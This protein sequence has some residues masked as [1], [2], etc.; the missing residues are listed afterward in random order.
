MAWVVGDETMHKSE[1]RRQAAARLAT[2]VVGVIFTGS[3]ELA[4]ADMRGRVVCGL[5]ADEAVLLTWQGANGFWSIRTPAG[6]RLGAFSTE[7]AALRGW[8]EAAS[9]VCEV[10]I[11]VNL[12]DLRGRLY[13]L[14]RKMRQYRE[15]ADGVY[16]GENDP[17]L[18]IVGVPADTGTDADAAG[19]LRE[20]QG[21]ARATT[22]ER[23]LRRL[24]IRLGL[25]GQRRSAVEGAAPDRSAVGDGVSS[26]AAGEELSGG[27][28]LREGDV[29]RDCDVCP[30]MVVMPGGRF[31]LGRYEVT[32]GEYRV[33]AS[34]AAGGAGQGCAAD[35]ALGWRD[36]GVL[37][38][39]S[40]PVTCVS[41]D[42]AQDY[43]TWLTG[44][45][46][47][48]YRLPTEEEWVLAIGGAEP[49]CQSRRDGRDG[50]CPV[51]SYGSNDVGLSDMVGNVWE[52]MEDCYEGDCGS[53][54]IRGGGWG[55][56]ER[57]RDANARLSE[58]RYNPP[59]LP[60]RRVAPS[61]PPVGDRYRSNLTG[62]RIARTIDAE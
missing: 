26:R 22:F 17:R 10:T 31:A 47:A 23:G 54:V 49:G 19:E 55:S 13:R 35:R 24:A 15:T 62:F 34:A 33:Y 58:W 21:M 46:G 48:R 8:E 9:L 45:S 36:P 4:T 25:E 18:L 5:P 3:G 56:D 60:G 41:W 2:L 43:V 16:E 53:R 50:T 11:V 29:F 27:S 42:D 59:P 7:R 6:G 40:H 39:E 30:E 37:Q 51:G 20:L 61:V 38:T 28:R 52:W 32:V 14:D 12:R 44:R 57:W 1:A